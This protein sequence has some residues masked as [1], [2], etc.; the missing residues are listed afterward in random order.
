MDPR[1]R[2]ASIARHFALDALYV[3]GSRQREAR[4]LVSDGTPFTTGGSDVDVG[5]LPAVD[6]RLDARQRVDLVA[7]LE[8]LFAGTI[9]DLVVLPEAPA[10]LAAD[11]VSGELLFVGD[12]RRE[13]DFQLHVLRRAADLAPFER[14]R[15]AIIL[16]GGR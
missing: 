9:V 14:E 10:F 3:F 15:R 13:A 6:C 5:V 12:R 4:A 7:A 16:A 1:S 2:L 8:G 11:V